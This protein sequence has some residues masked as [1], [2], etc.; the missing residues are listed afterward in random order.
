MPLSPALALSLFYLTSFG[1]FGVYLP[2]F[3]VY[4]EWLGLTGLEIGVVSALMPL[5][6][7]VVPA[8][9]GLLSDRLGRRSLV[10]VLSS[11]C[12]TLAFALL[13]GARHFAAIVTIVA[14][15]ALLRAPAVPLVDA[16]AM[17]VAEAG[18]PH[19]GRMR[20]WGSVAFIVVALLTGRAVG[21]WGERMAVWILLLLLALNVL[22]A[23]VLPKD[24]GRGPR[25]PGAGGL[26]RFLRTPPVLLFLLA[27]V[28]SQAAHGPYYV[29][30]SIHLKKAGYAPTTI[31]LL[32]ALAVGCEIVAMLRVPALLRRVGTLPVMAAALLLAAVRWGICALTV[33]PAGM[34]V[35]QALHAASFAAFHVSAV[36]HTHHLFGE[37]RRASGQA[38][39]TSATYG[40][41]NVVGMILSGIAYDRVPVTQMFGGAAA[42]ALLGAL[43]VLAAR[44]RQPAAPGGI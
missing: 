15:W 41:G 14:A 21:V 31:G 24:R 20:V 12:A 13:L 18:G 5:S 23:L 25:P 43:L 22:A 37:K 1:A 19:Y 33:A 3:N 30:Y 35:A 42:T 4:L 38:V 39:Y 34:V 26:W 36:T 27:C 9:G 28:L 16:T 29:F 6:N 40:L 32:W 7:V 44:R 8:F 17:E 11:L 2:Y 10:V